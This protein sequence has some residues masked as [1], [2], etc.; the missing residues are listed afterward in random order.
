MAVETPR[1]GPGVCMVQKDFGECAF[2]FI[3]S[4]NIYHNHKCQ[5]VAPFSATS[6]VSKAVIPPDTVSSLDVS[7]GFRELQ[8]R[9]A[10]LLS[11]LFAGEVEAYPNANLRQYQQ[12]ALMEG[13]EPDA[14]F[15]L[16]SPHDYLPG[17]GRAA[18]L[19]LDR[20]Y[21]GACATLVF[22]DA[23]SRAQTIAN[24]DDCRAAILGQ[25]TRTPGG[26]V[27]YT[28]HVVTKDHLLSERDSKMTH[29]LSDCT[30]KS[31]ADLTGLSSRCLGSLASNGA[32][33]YKNEL[34]GPIVEADP[35]LTN[36]KIESG[37]FFIIGTHELWTTVST[38]EAPSPQFMGF[39][40]LSGEE[41]A[42]ESKRF[43]MHC[44]GVLG[45]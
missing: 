7:P 28:A 36:I 8:R 34:S 14:R 29:G 38:E 22:Y 15:V 21:S 20:V 6:V 31:I 32:V 5:W 44:N 4:V 3:D 24:F 33:M 23:A 17:R 43:A 18:R 9:R 25:P 2:E 39:T 1:L 30:R 26:R 42:S 45:G 11:H 37:D 35:D 16:D 27:T 12:Q 13:D 41:N 10:G 40:S 19:L